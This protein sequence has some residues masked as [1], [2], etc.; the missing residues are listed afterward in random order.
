MH[1][2]AADSVLGRVM[3]QHKQEHQSSPIMEDARN[4][5]QEEEEQHYQ[6]DQ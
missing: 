3:R 6:T 2:Y 1:E 5:S 4:F